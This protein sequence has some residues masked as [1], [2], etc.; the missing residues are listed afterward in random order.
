MPPSRV[1]WP[2][3]HSLGLF[4]GDLPQVRLP[5]RVVLVQDLGEYCG[6]SSPSPAWYVVMIGPP[7]FT[8]I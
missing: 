4:L 3:R 1:W 6:S 5:V 2:L 7:S 8:E